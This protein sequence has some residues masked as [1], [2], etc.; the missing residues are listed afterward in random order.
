[1]DRAGWYDKNSG[2][3][4]HDVKG[5]ARNAFG[6]Y[7]MLGNVYEWTNDWYAPK[8]TGGTDPQGPTSGTGKVLRGG[9]WISNSRDLRASHRNDVGLSLRN[10]LFGFRC[11]WE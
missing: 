10:H 6:L 11:G 8:L 5:K 9:S 2:R 4:T 3:E 1:V 7:D